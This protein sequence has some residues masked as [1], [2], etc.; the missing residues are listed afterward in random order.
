MKYTPLTSYRQ[1]R[2]IS[3]A[4]SGTTP[5]SVET[6]AQ[7]HTCENLHPHEA[8]LSHNKTKVYTFDNTCNLDQQ[9]RFEFVVA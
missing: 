7:R 4:R 5:E 9:H 8:L 6:I 1:S 2:I 3:R